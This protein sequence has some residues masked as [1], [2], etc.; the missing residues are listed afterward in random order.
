[1]HSVG[2]VVAEGRDI[3]FSDWE[4]FAAFLR[5]VLIRSGRQDLQI[6]EQY[7]SERQFCNESAR[8]LM[9]RR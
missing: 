5:H 6:R 3:R 4:G 9:G 8:P 7:V 2:I 1:M